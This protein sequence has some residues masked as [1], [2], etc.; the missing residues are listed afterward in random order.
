VPALNFKMEV[1]MESYILRIYRR[2]K[3]IPQNIIG[4]IEDVDI[5]GTR[6]FHSTDDIAGILTGEGKAIKNKKVREKRRI[7]RL[8]LS[9]PV[10]VDGVADNGESFTEDT[11]ITNISSYGAYINIKNHVNKDSGVSLIIDP[12]DSC[13]NMKARVVRVEKGRSKTGIGVAFI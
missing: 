7:A 3:D 9:L 2:N 8:K 13:L 6:P 11:T 10:K 4:T 1:L 5:G 12:E